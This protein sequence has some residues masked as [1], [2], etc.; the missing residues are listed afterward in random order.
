M[1][2]EVIIKALISNQYPELQAS[3][4]ADELMQ[5]DLRLLPLLENWINQGNEQDFTVEGF[6]LLSLKD[7]YKLTYPA[8]L[9]TID[10]LIKDPQTASYAIKRGIK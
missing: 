6:S 4:V 2:K 8:A 9:L 1:N 3:G 7:Q 10:W 5:I